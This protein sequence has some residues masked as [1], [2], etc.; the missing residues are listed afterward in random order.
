MQRRSFLGAMLAAAAAPAIITTPGLLMPVKKLVVPGNILIGQTQLDWL[1]WVARNGQVWMSESGRIERVVT[2]DETR[3]GG[4][5]AV[6][7]TFYDGYA[8]S[9]DEKGDIRAQNIP[10]ALWEVA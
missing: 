5:I 6:D 7:S 9:I 4:L 1:A 3:H 8:W 10:F 2:R